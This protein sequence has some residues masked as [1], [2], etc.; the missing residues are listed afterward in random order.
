SFFARLN[1]HAGRY[2]DLDQVRVYLPV[3]LGH[4]HVLVDQAGPHRLRVAHA[5]GVH[6]SDAAAHDGAL[7]GHQVILP[8]NLSQVFRRAQSPAKRIVSKL[9]LKTDAHAHRAGLSRPANRVV[10]PV[11]IIDRVVPGA[12]GADGRVP[13]ILHSHGEVERI[14]QGDGRVV[15]I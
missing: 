4:L 2:V 10:V 8:I 13:I 7:T 1:L 14:T 5:R 3:D 11:G 15:E 9:I 6:D 12:D